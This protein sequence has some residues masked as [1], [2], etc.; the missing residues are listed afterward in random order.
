[1]TESV[2]ADNRIRLMASVTR[3]LNVLPTLGWVVLVAAILSVAY[4]VHTA[5]GM[6]DLDPSEPVEG[7]TE[8]VWGHPVSIVSDWQVF[9]G[10]HQAVHV[11][12]GS[13]ARR[14]RLAGTFLYLEGGTEARLAIIHD[15]KSGE[16]RIVAEQEEIVPGVRVVQ[17][18][19]DR[20]VVREG[21]REEELRVRSLASEDGGKGG[22]SDATTRAPAGSPKEMAQRLKLRRLSEN[23]WVISRDGLK[24]YYEELRTNPYRLQKLFDSME[25]AWVQPEGRR[26]YIDGYKLNIQGERAFYE[27]VGLKQNDRVKKVNSMPMRNRYQAERFIKNFAS[28]RANAFVLDIER[29]GKPVKLVYQI[30]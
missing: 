22:A 18:M 28:D 16:Q 20:A 29:D 15:I 14:F 23:S 4:L 6:P 13:L 30:R 10:E 1:M 7:G 25:P 17:I 9:R 27:G 21:E 11:P 24:D 5:L 26:R 12:A 8:L 3:H 19:E 2:S